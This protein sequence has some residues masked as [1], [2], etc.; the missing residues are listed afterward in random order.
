VRRL[1]LVLAAAVL[2]AA[3]GGDDNSAPRKADTTPAPN[4]E[5]KMLRGTCILA[6]QGEARIRFGGGLARQRDAVGEM[7]GNYQGFVGTL[8]QLDAPEQIAAQERMLPKVL[9]LR[10]QLPSADRAALAG[11]FDGVHQAYASDD[12]ADARAGLIDCIWDVRSSD[13]GDAYPAATRRGTMAKATPALAHIC[14]D[15][16]GRTARAHA[17]APEAKDA[18]DEGGSD[19]L[20][21]LVAN[22]PR[23]SDATPAYTGWTNAL[24]TSANLYRLAAVTK[25]ESRAKGLRAQAA[26]SAAAARKTAGELGLFDCAQR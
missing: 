12:A 24:K 15:N 6:A 9:K 7:I 25:D 23:P 20:V 26:R 3:C 17:L 10:D 8:K 14:L 2:L 11:I 1:A 21:R 16:R 4:P 19:R 18:I 5:M 13:A 22:V